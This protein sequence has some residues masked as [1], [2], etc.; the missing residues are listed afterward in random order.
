MVL[1]MGMHGSH[2][3]PGLGLRRPKIGRVDCI[4]NVGAVFCLSHHQLPK[5][6]IG[7]DRTHIETPRAGRGAQ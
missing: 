5:P 7:Q 6:S 2:G 4:G 3:G 1:P